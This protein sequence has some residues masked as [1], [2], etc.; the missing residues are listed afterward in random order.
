LEKKT[1][2]ETRRHVEELVESLS[3]PISG[4]SL[5][6]LRALAVLEHAGTPEARRLL[7]ALAGGASGA[8]LTQEAKASVERLAKQPK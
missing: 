8:W 3:G 2:L 5:R 7:E 1:S 4:E 6:T